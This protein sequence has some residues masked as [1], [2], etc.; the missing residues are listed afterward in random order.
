M[1]V[2]V[3]QIGRD[4][5]GL[6]GAV[7]L[8]LSRSARSESEVVMTADPETGKQEDHGPWR[9]YPQVGETRSAVSGVDSPGLACR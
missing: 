8:L 6:L 5:W 2:F 9:G 3:W 7:L 1:E 4:C